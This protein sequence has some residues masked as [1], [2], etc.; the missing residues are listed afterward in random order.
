M[1]SLAIPLHRGRWK[2]VIEYDGA[3]FAGWQRQTNAPSVQEAIERAIKLFCNE[4]VTLHVAGRTD[5][6]H[7]GL[8]GCDCARDSS[9]T[10][11]GS[12]ARDGH[13]PRAC[14]P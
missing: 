9:P 3:P 13:R 11:D 7:G 4:D 8:A 2:L 5:A 14:A 12:S 1:T 6:G 10:M